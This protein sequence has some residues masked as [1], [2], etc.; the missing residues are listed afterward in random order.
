VLIVVVGCLA[1][2]DPSPEVILAVVPIVVAAGVFIVR[3]FDT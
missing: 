3:S 1:V 2:L